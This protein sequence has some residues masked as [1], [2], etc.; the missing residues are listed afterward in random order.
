MVCEAAPCC[1]RPRRATRSPAHLDVGISSPAI[2][3]ETFKLLRLPLL[4]LVDLCLC[5]VW[6]CLHTLQ[7]TAT[8]GSAISGPASTRPRHWQVSSGH[9][10]TTLAVWLARA[11][12]AGRRGLRCR[13]PAKR[14]PGLC[15][16][17][18]PEKP[19]LIAGGGA[20]LVLRC[21]LCSVWLDLPMTAAT[22]AHAACMGCRRLLWFA[23]SLG[24]TERPHLQEM[25]TVP[26]RV[27]VACWEH[28]LVAREGCTACGTR[29]GPQVQPL[30]ARSVSRFH[31]RH[32]PRRCL[33]LPLRMEDVATLHGGP[34]QLVHS[35]AGG[36]RWNP[37]AHTDSKTWATRRAAA[38]GTREPQRSRAVPCFAAQPQTVFCRG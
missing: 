38:L 1:G 33:P 16:F 31:S 8:D 13:K 37:R 36:Q 28:C 6:K 26:A 3:H 34:H 5:S 11:D 30:C 14:W 7:G 25:R 2:K 17:P 12:R 21:T 32:L 29:L 20:G 15:R 4:V 27:F 22:P 9:G 10:P 19:K 24:R 35:P 23:G 18:D